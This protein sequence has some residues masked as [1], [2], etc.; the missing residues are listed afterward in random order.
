[1]SLH[2]VCETVI[3]ASRQLHFRNLL[4]QFKLLSFASP[5]ENEEDEADETLEVSSAGSPSFILSQEERKR[6]RG[7][8]FQRVLE[9]GG[10]CPPTDGPLMGF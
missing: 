6:E 1:M 2:L 8:Y 9:E 7:N 5:V 4:S 10:I 3:A